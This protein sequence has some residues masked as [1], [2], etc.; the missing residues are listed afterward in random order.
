[1]QG[2]AGECRWIQEDAVWIHGDARG[3][4][5]G[6]SGA[7][8]AAAKPAVAKPAAAAKADYNRPRHSIADQGTSWQTKPL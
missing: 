8:L 5:G 7:K 2:D 1:M 4:Q 6:C 3:L